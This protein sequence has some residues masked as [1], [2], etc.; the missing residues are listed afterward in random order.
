[1]GYYCPSIVII[2]QDMIGPDGERG[3]YYRAQQVFTEAAAATPTI[4]LPGHRIVLG[5]GAQPT[6]ANAAVESAIGWVEKHLEDITGLMGRPPYIDL[7][8]NARLMKHRA[9]DVG[10]IL[11][12]PSHVTAAVCLAPS[13][14][15]CYH[16]DGLATIL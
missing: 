3:R 4:Q 15:H 7:R 13:I 8:K 6:N 5:I 10:I 9:E 14:G 16:H 1:M 2:M 12:I 11:H